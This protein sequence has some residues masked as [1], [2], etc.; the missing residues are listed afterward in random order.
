VTSALTTSSSD[1]SSSSN[2]SNDSHLSDVSSGAEHDHAL[3]SLRHSYFQSTYRTRHFL[4]TVLSTRVL[5]PHNVPKCSQLGLVLVCYKDDDPSR[6]R[7]NLC[8]S[9]NTFD[10]LLSL[11][12]DHPSFHNN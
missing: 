12:Q 9:P 8:V 7:R 4:S 1:S 6:F 2:G 11:I 3:R 10:T 5:Y